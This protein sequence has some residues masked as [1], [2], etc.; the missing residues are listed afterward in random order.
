MDVNLLTVI[1]QVPL[2]QNCTNTP[3]FSLKIHPQRE[4]SGN[5]MSSTA[6]TT[7]NL[8]E[9]NKPL[10]CLRRTSRLGDSL[11]KSLSDEGKK[12]SSLTDANE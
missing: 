7:G 4:T 11:L 1:E 5:G 12:F 9:K 2:C 8:I 3:L 6:S 10:V